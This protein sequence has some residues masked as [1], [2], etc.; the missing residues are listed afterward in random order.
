MDSKQTSGASGKSPGSKSD[1]MFDSKVTRDFWILLKDRHCSVPVTTSTLGS[2]YL[3]RVSLSTGKEQVIRCFFELNDH[4]LLCFKVTAG[5][6]GKQQGA[7]GLSGP[8]VL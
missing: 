1:N 7:G 6:L 2:D 4:Y 5:L 8:G 3:F